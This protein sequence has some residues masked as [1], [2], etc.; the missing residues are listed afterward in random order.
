[1]TTGKLAARP[2]GHRSGR[3]ALHAT[4]LADMD[5][6]QKRN[7]PVSVPLAV[8]GAESLLERGL[9]FAALS[10]VINAD[11]R[12]HDP[13]YGA[14]RWWARRPPSLLRAALLAAALPADTP[15]EAFWALYGSSSPVL[16][17]LR[18][19][20]PFIGGGSTLV[21]AARL[22]ARV[23]G[24]DVDPLAVEL[25]RYELNPAPAEA[26]REAGRELLD[27]L[28]AE[29]GHLYPERRSAQ[30]LHSF[31]LHEVTCP[32]CNETGLLYRDLVLA[33]DRKK[34]GAVVRDAPLTVFCPA[35]LS[36]HELN[37]VD[38]VILRHKGTAWRINEGTFRGQRYHCPHCWS[39]SSHKELA[40]GVAPRR[41]VGVEY[42][43]AEAR[44]RIYKARK[45]DLAALE[46]ATA[47]LDE[48][49]P[50]LP[51]PT[52]E[53]CA[54]RH[55][56]RPRSFGMAT[57]QDLFTERQLAVF[58]SAFKWLQSA[59]LDPSVR[60]GLRLALSNALA[61]NNK[62]CSY[63]YDYGRLSALFSVRG[64]SLPTLA[65]E[66]NPL[67]PDSGRGTI[68][69]CI[70][71]VARAAASEVRRYTWS[72]NIGKP[73]PVSLALA[74]NADT[75]EVMCVDAGAA[76]DSNVTSADLCFFDP[77]YFDYIAYSELSEFYRAWVGLPP[78][79]AEP[80]LP[81]GDDPGE[82]FGLK[83]GVAMRAALARLAPGR[84]IAFTYHS[85]AREAWRAVGIA[86]DEAKLRVTALWPVRSDGHMG[87][88]SHPGNC[89]WDVLVVCRRIHET[90][91]AA[92]TFDVEDWQRS[93]HP[94]E[95]GQADRVSIDLAV[96]VASAR[97]GVITKEATR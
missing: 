5:V 31:W 55:D 77:P 82:D 54:E 61:T 93:A 24:G 95:I 7:E 29:L 58:G 44:R 1:M 52:A 80:L 11:R 69:N 53:L 62:L 40:T 39:A 3:P 70:E 50:T 64:Y 21:E 56:E 43:S 9:P 91:P 49:A 83:L 20:D 42:T 26:V 65:V 19:H 63:A 94:L 38:R 79:D 81:A 35:D 18:V 96:E 88:H 30:P 36:V 47:W 12:V 41:L 75:S 46:S 85:T 23:S 73:A 8:D 78:L 51:L 72:T 87:H 6:E 2:D 84:P 13:V 32:A 92:A 33:R 25:V 28:R 10:H 59:E 66:L 15:P 76:A 71:R 60:T 89:E 17:G 37:R 97:F 74:T 34:I 14:H 45:A 67:H 48:N 4:L 22:G 90:S 27:H 86:L 16:A 68:H 57:V